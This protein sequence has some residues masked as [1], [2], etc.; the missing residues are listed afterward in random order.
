MAADTYTYNSL[1]PHRIFY[2]DLGYAIPSQKKTFCHQAIIVTEKKQCVHKINQSKEEKG[3]K[4]L[5]STEDV[6]LENDHALTLQS[7][8]TVRHKRTYGH[9]VRW[10]YAAIMKR[11]SSLFSYASLGQNFEEGLGDRLARMRSVAG[12]QRELVEGCE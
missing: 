12:A 5:R 3:K 9:R 4:V 1:T 11:L 6:E 7:Y 10:Q 8:T 2:L